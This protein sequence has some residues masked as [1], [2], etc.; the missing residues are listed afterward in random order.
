MARV[1]STRN[2][3][4]GSTKKGLRSI[5]SARIPAIVV[6]EEE[7]DNMDMGEPAIKLGLY[8]KHPNASVIADRIQST[9]G[10]NWELADSHFAYNT[11]YLHNEKEVKKVVAELK[12]DGLIVQFSEYAL[13]RSFISSGPRGTRKS[14]LVWQKKEQRRL[15]RT[16]L[17]RRRSA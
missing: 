4:T 15:T 6:V 11:L 5:A 13:P 2:R 16:N 9:Y 17:K 3:A 1:S 10:S 8:I 7:H 14:S 12:R